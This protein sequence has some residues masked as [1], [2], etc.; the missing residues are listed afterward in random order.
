MST[1]TI[2]N[3]T[4]SVELTNTELT[5]TDSV[6]LTNTEL[7]MTDSVEL[8]DST[9]SSSTKSIRIEFKIGEATN[10]GGN[11]NKF[12]QD[13]H[14]IIDMMADFGIMIHGMLDGHGRDYGHHVAEDIKEL[15]C[16]FI[17]LNIESIVQNPEQKI[18]EA[19]D[20]AS[21]RYLSKLEDKLTEDGYVVKNINNYLFVKNQNMKEWKQVHAGT[22]CT[23]V[24]FINNCLYTYTTGDSSA[25]LTCSK[26]LLSQSMIEFVADSSLSA[27][28]SQLKKELINQ[29]NS[30]STELTNTLVIS[31][32]SSVEDK[33]E[34]E[35]MCKIRPKPNNPLEPACC[36]VY[37][38]HTQDKH[39]GNPV[40]KLNEQHKLTVTK[41]GKSY[42]NV[43]REF[44]SLI[45]TPGI[46][47][48]TSNESD[49]M[50]LDQ[51]AL[52]YTRSF[53]DRGLIPYGLTHRPVIQ[54]LDL[55]EIIKNGDV[56]LCVV[57]AT[58]GIYDNWKYE[59]ITDYVL[60]ESCINAVQK[61]ANGAQDVAMAL[62][63]RNNCYGIRNFKEDRDNASL[64]VTFIKKVDDVSEN[65]SIDS[66]TNV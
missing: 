5:M 34:Y 15:L 16:E 27:E 2:Q 31:Y 41:K 58:D 62:D 44:A 12:N 9:S 25:L 50:V 18:V 8:T 3:N 23:V 54:K 47:E 30:T 39:L 26:P 11:K 1:F 20:F 52:A 48:I 49:S 51:D 28:E 63:E 66:T 65:I 40:F 59:D 37:D 64:I 7:T 10:I 13:R 38:N 22:S 21:E 61:T 36:F 60:H 46:I 24:V 19:F 33:Y 32:D 35:R 53:G 56:T 4:D 6:E 45:C 14:F 55:T 42:K 17:N 43:R 57:L 29:E